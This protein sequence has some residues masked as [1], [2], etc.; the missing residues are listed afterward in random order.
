MNGELLRLPSLYFALAVVAGIV[1]GGLGFPNPLLVTILTGVSVL[2]VALAPIQISRK[3]LIPIFAV[4][5]LL[6]ISFS[7]AALNAPDHVNRMV[8]IRKCEVEGI[9]KGPIEYYKR[10]GRFAL[11]V[12][13]L[14]GQKASGL[15]QVGLY[16]NAMPPIPGDR[17][18]LSNAYLK[19]VIGFKNFGGFDK[20]EYYRES[21]ITVVTNLSKKDSLSIIS[22]AG[23]WRPLSTAE[24]LRRNIRDF[25]VREYPKVESASASAMTIGTRGALTPREKRAY[26]S[27]G[28]AHLLAVAGLHVGFISAFSYL[29]FYAFFFYL[30][31]LLRPEWTQSGAHRKWAALFCI[32]AVVLYVLVTGANIPSRRAGIMATI[33]FLSMIFGREGEII[34]SLAVS[35]I[36]I[37]LLDPRALSSFSFLMSYTAVTAIALM[38]LR[39]RG[40]AEPLDGLLE[41]RDAFSKTAE[42]FWD[43]AKISILLAFV[44]APLLM[45]TFNEVN[46][47]S[48]PANIIA[49]PIAMFAVP[50]VFVAHALGNLWEPLGSAVAW[51]SSVAFS[52]IEFTAGFFG[53]SKLL[54]FSGP[55][56]A[57]WLSALFYAVFF[58]WVF[59]SRLFASS[60]V[61]LIAALLAFYWPAER[62]FSE[63]RI[64]DVGQGDST[65]IMLKD[66][67]NILIDGGVRIGDYDLGEIVILPELR[68]LGIKKLDAV[69]ATHGDMDHVGG[70]F[71]V[72]KGIKVARYMDNGE[73]H[74][75]LSALRAIA[76]EA[77]IPRFGLHA[78]MRLP[79]SGVADFS[80]IHPSVEFIKEH[81]NAKNN[82]ISLMILL[83]TE[84]RTA[85]LPADCE[86]ETENF[87]MKKN[88]VPKAEVLHVG[89]HGSGTSTTPAFLLAV[90]PKIAVISV[91]KLNRY[92]MPAKKT[93]QALHDA[94]L[95]IL[96]TQD[97]GDVSLMVK[98]GKMS[99]KTFANPEPRPLF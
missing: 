34:N 38:L 15:V 14:N 68:R 60:A 85:L 5:G 54:S 62:T 51:A 69:I 96:Q 9:V 83:A 75:A 23:A 31:Y 17:V 22:E 11:S 98:D 72:M 24:R 58:L 42:F 99:V 74:K 92:R 47:F 4:A 84:G 59:R 67:K 27:S 19:P 90:S 76:D 33:F 2:I 52:G 10:G 32:L 81:P 8:P 64:I 6:S 48:V 7:N 95:E 37:L 61:V 93:M 26:S 49:V 3:P 18:L 82:N 12:E 88:A 25:I 21:G 66:G 13:K 30:F 16:Y 39:G 63:V 40:K 70:L 1:V 50:S 56:P 45:R 46:A 91:G 35:A 73:P 87:L 43:V 77:D 44:T 53:S 20:E 41:K 65:L 57:M 89:H 36:A 78:G 97:E 29:I 71:S 28:L 94:N 80:V 79:L 86:K 55:P